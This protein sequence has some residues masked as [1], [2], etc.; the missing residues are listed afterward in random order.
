M[1][2]RAV[3]LTEG[4]SDPHTAKTACSLLRYR[5]DEVVGVLDST[6]AGQP[7]AEVLGV[8]SDLR[9]IGSL[10]AVAGADTLIIGIAPPG[11]K[12]PAPWRVL[13][14][15]AIESGMSIVSGLHDFL[16]DDREFSELAERHGVELVDVRK[17][18]FKQIA[19]CPPLRRECT[20]LLTVGHD[21]SVGKMV[22]AIELANALQCRGHSAHFAATGQTG[23]MV[24]GG[25]LPIDCITADFVSGAAEHLVAQHQQN[26]F[27]V[28]EGQGSL[29]HPSYSPVTLGI[30]HGA[31]PHGVIM[32]YEVG[33]ETIT[34]LP[35]LEIPPLARILELTL[36]AAAAVQPCRC[37]GIAVN[38]RLVDEARVRREIEWAEREFGVPACDV[39]R[40]GCEPLVRAAEELHRQRCADGSGP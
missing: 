33:R 23:I 38:G 3:L 31:R 29:V 8:P 21:C 4:H 30:L 14:R 2:R 12:I 24:S 19:R 9:F 6:R 15:Q 27:V 5:P 37:I 26:D 20:R 10:D 18:D 32:C 35:H 25:G 40:D 22:T 17:N 7:V 1:P 11:G 36:Q 34:G 16:S 39:F 28:V 13:I